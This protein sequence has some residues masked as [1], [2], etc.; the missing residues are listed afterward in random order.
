MLGKPFHKRGKKAVF[1]VLIAHIVYPSKHWVLHG[2]EVAGS[3][4]SDYLSVPCNRFEHEAA[5]LIRLMLQKNY[6]TLQKKC[7]ITIFTY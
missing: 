7:E 3:Q 6:S 4:P 1:A 2:D 5:Q